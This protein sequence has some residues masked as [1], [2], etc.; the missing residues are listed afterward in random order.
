M[1]AKR[2]FPA[3]LDFH[4]LGQT[5]AIVRIFLLKLLESELGHRKPLPLVELNMT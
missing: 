1:G 4:D 3:V 5:G 2:G